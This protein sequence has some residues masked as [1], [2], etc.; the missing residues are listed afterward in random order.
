[1]VVKKTHFVE[2]IEMDF[3]L[4]EERREK[5][6]PVPDFKARPVKM[7]PSVDAMIDDVKKRFPK[8]LAYLAK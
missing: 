1:M 5:R 4:L 3:D 2:K 8:T 7:R 6:A